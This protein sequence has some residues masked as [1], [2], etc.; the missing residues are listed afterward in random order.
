MRTEAIAGKR[1]DRK[2]KARRKALPKLP[3][4]YPA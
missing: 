3:K 1:P 2:R 4:R